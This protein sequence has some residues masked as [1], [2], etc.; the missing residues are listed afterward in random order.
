MSLQCYLMS[1]DATLPTKGSTHAAGWDIYA[2]KDTLITERGRAKVETHLII[3]YPEGHYA[4]VAPRS[5][6]AFKHGIDVGAGVVDHGK[7]HYV[8]SNIILNSPLDYRGEVGVMLFNHSD[9]DFEV[10]KGDRVAQVI[11]EK[12]AENVT[13]TQVN[14]LEELGTTMR[15]QKGFGSTGL[16]YV[17]E[18]VDY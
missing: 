16:Q 6:L 7:P 8:S 18:V 2:A 1:T 10:K 12:I 14:S 3:A 15:G 13:V 11:L 9:Q 5:G 17:Y 4:R